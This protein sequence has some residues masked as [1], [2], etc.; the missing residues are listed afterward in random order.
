MST[1]ARSCS[2]V[3]SSL[4]CAIGISDFSAALPR[5]PLRNGARQ[6]T[7]F[8]F[9]DALWASGDQKYVD[10]WRNMINSVNSHATTI[11]GRLQYP[12]MYG[13]DGWYGW[14]A[15]P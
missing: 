5:R 9:N 1:V 6:R 14:Q 12:T 11:N 7:R 4:T 10:A 15:Q 3:T 8:G 13:S 2:K